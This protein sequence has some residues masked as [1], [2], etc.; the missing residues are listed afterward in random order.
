M[1]E[2][3]GYWFMVSLGVLPAVIT[4]LVICEGYAD[5]QVKKITRGRHGVDLLKYN[6]EWMS[7]VIIIG[8]IEVVIMVLATLITVCEDL[9]KNLYVD[10]VDST[11]VFFAPVAVWVFWLIVAFMIFHVGV[12]LWGNYLNLSDTISDKGGGKN[13]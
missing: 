11:A 9:K 7:V 10:M 4:L 8:L 5:S 2:I 13:A 3:I 1:S 12:T 6:P